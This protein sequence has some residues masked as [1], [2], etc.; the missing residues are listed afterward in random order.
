[1]V[2]PEE[3]V[4]IS[5][6]M[7]SGIYILLWKGEPVYIGQSVR[8][9]SRVTSH[10]NLKG[11]VRKSITSKALPAIR[12][13]AVWVM[14]CV[15]SDLD[16]IEKRMIERYQPRYNINHKLKPT[17]SLDMLVDMMPLYPLLPP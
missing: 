8:L 16:R 5:A 4:D 9:C 10:V 14:P 11:K 13:D 15:L 6:V 12:F 2:I 1:M 3:F 17:M 7:R